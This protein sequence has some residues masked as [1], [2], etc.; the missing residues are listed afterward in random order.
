MIKYH[1]IFSVKYRKSLLNLVGDDIKRLMINISNKYNFDVCE[2]E[3]DNNHIH[4][5]IDSI[6]TLSPSMIIRVLKQQ[7]TRD[8][9]KLHYV[10]LKKHFWKEKTFWADGYFVSSIG[11]ASISTIKNYIKNQG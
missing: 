6:P 1:I 4:F 5:L 11:D 10:L 2:M 8:I 7:S 9:W 3:I